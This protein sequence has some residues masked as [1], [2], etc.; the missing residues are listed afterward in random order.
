MPENL[1]NSIYI[2]IP[3]CKQKCS[4]CD[5]VSFSGKENLIDAYVDK[6]NGEILNCCRNAI[7]RVPTTIYFGGGT[8]TLL[9]P[10]HFRKIIDSIKN[11]ELGAQNTENRGEITIEANPGTVNREY[12]KALRDL[13]INRISLGAQSFNDK[14]LKTLGR[15]HDS[16]QICKAVE[17]AKSAGFGNI[18][19]DLIFAIPNQT[20]DE[21]KYDLEQAIK[22]EPTHISTYNLQIEEGTPLF[23]KI[24]TPFSEELDAD[25]YEYTI[26]FLKSYGYKHYEISNFAKPAFESKHNLNYWQNGNY[27]G[28]GAG[29]H[30]HIDGKRWSNPEAI[31]EYL[32]N[33][34]RRDA[35][36]RVSTIAT[37]QSETILM[38]LRLIDGIPI[39]KF[40]GYEEKVS[41]LIG[42]GL[43]EQKNNKIKLS[44][45]G[46][47]LANLVFENFV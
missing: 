30:S 19:I 34:Y 25:M 5:F 42:Q 24:K 12:L 8:P 11:T 21:W 7:N 33:D 36:N 23:E 45:R 3:F 14:H 27:L 37:D 4:Y 6:L 26:D 10:E 18:S 22:L 32:A 2:H 44:K 15:I 16:K 28:I 39:E 9:Q 47:M 41:K 17:D 40:K 20:L 43:L 1:I 38:G 13:G 35:I 29:A 46:L 31:E